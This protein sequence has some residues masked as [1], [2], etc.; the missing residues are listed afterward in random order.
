MTFPR[1]ALVLALLVLLVGGASADAPTV[2]HDG[3]PYVDLARLAGDLKAKADARS[4]AIN[5]EL[6]T[7]G[8]VVRFTRNWSQILVDGAP[9]VLDAPVRVKDGRWLIPKSFVIDVLPRVT[10]SA[11]AYVT[12]APSASPASS[13]VPVATLDEMRVRSYPSFT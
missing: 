8:H 10:D 11:R 9:V 3:L 1:V 7:G 12:P 13:P 5:A 4:G 2:V 6:R